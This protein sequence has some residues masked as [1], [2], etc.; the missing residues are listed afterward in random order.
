MKTRII[1]DPNIIASALLGGITRQRFDWLL[2]SLDQFEICYSDTLIAEISALSEVLYFRK[3]GITKD[4]IS[5]FL[6][7]FQTFAIKIIPS[8]NV[9]V[10]RDRNDFYLLGLSR[11]ARAK[12]LI[13]GDPDLLSVKK[14]STT[15]IISLKEFE[16]V[17]TT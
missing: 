11:D 14:Y 17:F 3:K 13:T 16:E 6:K 4:R 2:S 15:L 5:G 7:A 12:Y 10:G 9:R 8:S 1:I